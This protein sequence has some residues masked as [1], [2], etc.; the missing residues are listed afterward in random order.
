MAADEDGTGMLF[1]AP[2]IAKKAQN[3]SVFRAATWTP[4]DIEFAVGSAHLRLY[5]KRLPLL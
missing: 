1:L 2:Y 5:L 4:E 3:N